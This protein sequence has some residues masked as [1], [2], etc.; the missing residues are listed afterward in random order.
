MLVR[1][2]T[3]PERPRKHTGARN[4]R[5]AG[6]TLDAGEARRRLSLRRQSVMQKYCYE[7]PARYVI[8]A[9]RCVSPSLVGICPFRA[10]WRCRTLF[11]PPEQRP[12]S[13]W[14]LAEWAEGHV[15]PVFA[16][17]R[18]FIAI[19][20][21]SSLSCKSRR[22]RLRSL[23]WRPSERLSRCEESWPFSRHPIRMVL[24]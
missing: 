7:I 17:R 13:F 3:R 18:P 8:T 10:K 12:F 11:P 15:Y 4:A 24:S 16:Q 9:A 20:S 1:S 5:R 6:D 14:S 21:A 22:I 23:R 19:R 2:I